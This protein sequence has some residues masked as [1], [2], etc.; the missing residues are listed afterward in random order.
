MPNMND[1]VYEEA[2]RCYNC[3]QPGKFQKKMKAPNGNGKIEFYEC[4]TMGCKVNTN[5]G[6]WMIQIARDGSIPVRDTSR[7]KEFPVMDNRM[8]NRASSLLDQAAEPPTDREGRPEVN[9]P[10]SPQR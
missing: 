8:L 2:K 4:E 7:D 9:N 5:G 1:T 10:W 6:T 3:L